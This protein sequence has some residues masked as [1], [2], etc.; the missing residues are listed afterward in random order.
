MSKYR[1]IPTVVD[2]IRFHSKKE[3][4]HYAVLKQRVHKHEICDLELQPKFLIN[5]NGIKICTYI[6]D[7]RYYD[8]RLDHYITEDVK[9]FDTAISKLKRKLTWALHGVEVRIV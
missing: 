4:S 9:G 6:A 8:K 5:L 3:A 2:G 7:F 1:A